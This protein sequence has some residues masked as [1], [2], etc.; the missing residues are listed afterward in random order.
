M[1]TGRQNTE[2][3]EKELKE[4]ERKKREAL[5]K[6]ICCYSILAAI[7]LSIVGGIIIY[8]TI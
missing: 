7:I 5:R 1:E 3:A 4:A 2:E 8:Y 6:K